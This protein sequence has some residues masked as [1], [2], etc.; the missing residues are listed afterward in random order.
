MNR[1]ELKQYIQNT[2]NVNPDYP[3]VKQPDNEVFR[4]SSNKKWFALIMNVE[5]SK[6]GLLEEGML[7]VVN[8]KCD[9]TL[10]GSLHNKNGI[11][12]AY[13][14]NKANWITVALDGSVDE[15]TIKMLVDLSYEATLKN[16]KK[17]YL[18]IEEV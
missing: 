7:E 13:H 8:L 2:F 10:L 9:A 17:N 14:M 11:F 1:K 16:G 15:E 18:K 12:P 6:L 4:H 5:K 3:W